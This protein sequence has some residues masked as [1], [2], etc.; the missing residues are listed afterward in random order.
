MTFDSLQKT[1]KESKDSN[2]QSFFVGQCLTNNELEMSKNDLESEIV[3]CE[4]C[5][6]PLR[7]GIN[8]EENSEEKHEG[9]SDLSESLTRKG[10]YEVCKICWRENIFNYI[11]IGSYILFGLLFIV[12]IIGVAYDQLSLNICLIIGCLEIIFL[13]FF[14]RFLEEAVFF[15]LTKREKL[16]AALYRYSVSA[17]LQAFDVALKHLGKNIIVDSELIR[18][19]LQVIIYQPTN[20]PTDWFVDISHRIGTTPKGF[21][22]KLVAEIDEPSEERYI[23][24]VIK[25][26][27]PSG[28][29]LLVE[30]FLITKSNYGLT[31][32]HERIVTELSSESI[33]K[34]FLNEFYIYNQKYQKA[35]QNIEKEDT[36]NKIV[37]S[38]EDFQEPKVPSIDVIESS[39]NIIQR[40][41]FLRRIFRLFLYIFL[42]F[43]LGLLYQLFD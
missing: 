1:T 3:R 15:G 6:F 34:K 43:I 2:N 41:P 32:L 24:K 18:G 13:L 8:S 33:D 17:E 26:A 14:G 39:K 4:Q 21:I 28:I 27:P 31:L 7:S 36:Y 10:K 12:G 19:L 42:A 16:L 29:S 23:R 40:N 35:L 11:L 25:Q 5:R 9:L 20:L 30:L 37:D 22:D 38:M